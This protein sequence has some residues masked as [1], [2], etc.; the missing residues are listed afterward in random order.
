MKG[1]VLKNPFWQALNTPP[2]DMK[3]VHA[4]FIAV[5]YKDFT[6]ENTIDAKKFLKSLGYFMPP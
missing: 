6:A 2:I 5:F 1:K 4:K 3:L